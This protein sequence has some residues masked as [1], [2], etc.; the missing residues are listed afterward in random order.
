MEDPMNSTKHDVQNT[1][2]FKRLAE[3][4]KADQE[5][6]DA[7][8]EPLTQRIFDESLELDDRIKI[9][10]DAVSCTLLA[11]DHRGGYQNDMNGHQKFIADFKTDFGFDIREYVKFLGFPTFKQ[12]LSSDYMK[13]YVI[14][15]VNSK[16]ESILKGRPFENDLLKELLEEQKAGHE[17]SEKKANDKVI[18]RKMRMDAAKM[19]PDAIEGRLRI[20]RCIHKLTGGKKWVSYQDVQNE[21]KNAYNTP[22]DKSEIKKYFGSGNTIEALKEYTTEDISLTQNETGAYYLKLK[23]EFDVIEEKYKK[24][25]EDWKNLPNMDEIA[26]MNKKFNDN[27]RHPIKSKKPAIVP[28]FEEEETSGLRT[29]NALFSEWDSLA[30]PP[31][32]TQT[33]TQVRPKPLE[34]SSELPTKDR[35]PK[36]Q[37][38]AKAGY[39]KLGDGNFS[40]DTSDDE[41]PLPKSSG[42]SAR[43]RNTRQKSNSEDSEDEKN[44]RSSFQRAN[45]EAKGE[46]SNLNGYPSNN[47]HSSIRTQVNGGAVNGNSSLDVNK[48]VL[49]AFIYGILKYAQPLQV[50]VS[51]IIKKAELYMRSQALEMSKAQIDRFIRVDLDAELQFNSNGRFV[52]L[53]KARTPTK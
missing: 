23:Q 46:K 45:L 28:I 14:F 40:S 11:Y 42:S 47:D 36:K 18:E 20:Y 1:K 10:G 50:P 48:L 30:S 26:S 5:A 7:E 3:V 37:N 39:T 8:L 16:N 53:A 24:T 4:T 34:K 13:E 41:Q 12:F 19:N 17:V 32:R 6:L 33:Q 38:S 51:N 15:T 29:K 49:K 2:E 44:V 27:R 35:E 43:H 31:S 52:S 22:L 25:L 9:L 21:Y